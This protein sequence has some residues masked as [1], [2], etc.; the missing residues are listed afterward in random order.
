MTKQFP[1]VSAKTVRGDRRVSVLLTGAASGLGR[2]LAEKCLD[3][4]FFVTAVVRRK[5]RKADVPEAAAG[6]VT[7]LVAD[8]SDRQQVDRLA[9]ELA[10]SRFDFVVHNAGTGVVGPF[11][12]AGEAALE[13]VLQ[14]NLIAPMQ[15]TRVLL[16]RALEEGTK[17]VFV[18]SLSARFP[19]PRAIGYGVSKAGL[20][21][22][23]QDLRA[24]YPS[25]PVLCAEI[26]PVA[27]PMH[28]KAGNTA[29]DTQ[30]FKDPGV[31]GGKLFD[32]MRKRTGVVTLDFQ[33]AVARK[34]A[35]WTD[36]FLT[37]LAGRRRP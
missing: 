6:R 32:A 27:T 29:A 13:R 18:S 21:K 26:G 20:S 10:D 22:F 4:G 14:T 36:G 37:W 9:G 23:A 30:H 16:P 1:D 31:I 15:L 25:L 8:L 3:A 33:W 5:D 12:Q 17:F 2:V 19:S 34:F 24:E 35:L 11:D 7:V 28:G